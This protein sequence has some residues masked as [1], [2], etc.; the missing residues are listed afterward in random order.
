MKNIVIRPG[1]GRKRKNAEVKECS[2]FDGVNAARRQQGQN[3]S[4]APKY[5]ISR[6]NY[7]ITYDNNEII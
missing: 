1:Y 4:R 2:A 3:L 7:P 5:V 6:F